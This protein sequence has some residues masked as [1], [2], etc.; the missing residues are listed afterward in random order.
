MALT[1]GE[2]K[3]MLKDMP[4]DTPIVKRDSNFELRGAITQASKYD[5]SIQSYRSERQTFMDAFDGTAY[6]HEVFIMDDEN[7]KPM[8]MV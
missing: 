7:G 4:D 2:L 3:E 5:L 6:Q 1:V 8:L